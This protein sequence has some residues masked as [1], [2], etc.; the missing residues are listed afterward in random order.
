MTVIPGQAG[1]AQVAELPDS[2]DRDGSMPEWPDTLAR[3]PHDV[4]MAVDLRD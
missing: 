1:S 3:Q 2:P 4:E